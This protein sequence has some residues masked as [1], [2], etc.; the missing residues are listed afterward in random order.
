MNPHIT[1]RPDCLKDA[2][3]AGFDALTKTLSL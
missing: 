2:F 1:H 3:Q